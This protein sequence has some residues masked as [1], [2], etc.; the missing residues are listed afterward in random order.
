MP[1]FLARL[2]RRRSDPSPMPPRELA[3]VYTTPPTPVPEPVLSPPPLQNWSHPFKDKRDP[4]QQLTHMANATAGFYPPHTRKF[5]Q[6]PFVT[7][8]YELLNTEIS[9]PRNW[10]GVPS[11]RFNSR[12]NH[13]K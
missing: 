7:N 2:L 11:D 4:L 9:N 5:I 6:K 1:N 3:V 12:A 10:V 13:L 8:D